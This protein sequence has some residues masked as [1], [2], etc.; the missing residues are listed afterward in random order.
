[1]TPWRLV[2]PRSRASLTVSCAAEKFTKLFPNS[3]SSRQVAFSSSSLVTCVIIDGEWSIRS[4]TQRQ[5]RFRCRKRVRGV[6][7]HA[8]K[9]FIFCHSL[10]ANVHTERKNKETAEKRSKQCHIGPNYSQMQR[11]K[12]CKKLFLK[13]ATLKKFINLTMLTWNMTVSRKPHS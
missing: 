12:V 2:T 8:K 4:V 7:A 11:L 10:S 5:G 3:P 9:I 13:V 1:M 6:M